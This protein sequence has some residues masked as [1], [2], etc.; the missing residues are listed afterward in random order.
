MI[1]VLSVIMMSDTVTSLEIEPCKKRQRHIKEHRRHNVEV[2]HD[3][4][5]VPTGARIPLECDVTSFVDSQTIVL[6]HN[7][8]EIR[9][10]QFK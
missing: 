8:T 1:T 9:C 10:D 2:T 3:R 7:N 5:S 4:N 6:V